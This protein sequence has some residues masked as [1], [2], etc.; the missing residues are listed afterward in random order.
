[1]AGGWRGGFVFRRGFWINISAGE[2]QCLTLR[3]HTLR[4]GNEATLPVRGIAHAHLPT[5]AIGQDNV[6]HRG[7][8]WK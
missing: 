5:T 7:W 6:R 1:M 8:A 3:N 2:T 4:G